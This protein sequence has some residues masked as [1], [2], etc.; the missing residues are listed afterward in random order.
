MMRRVLSIL[1]ASLVVALACAVG[2]AQADIDDANL[3]HETNGRVAWDGDHFVIRLRSGKTIAHGRPKPFV[4]SRVVGLHSY[5]RIGDVFVF[6]WSDGDIDHYTTVDEYSGVV[7]HFDR[8]P[9]FSPSGNR[10]VEIVVGEH[11]ESFNQRRAI[12]IWKRVGRSFTRVWSTRV[13]GSDQCGHVRWISDNEVRF[14]CHVSPDAEIGGRRYSEFGMARVAVLR[15]QGR[16]RLVFR[17][18]EAKR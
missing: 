4:D 2:D 5:D 9:D 13:K 11:I 14:Q 15:K 7:T 16:W 12:N 10:A 1:A 8:P 3:A 18:S 6:H 17:R